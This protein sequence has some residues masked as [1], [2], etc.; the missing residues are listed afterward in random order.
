MP[1]VVS[2]NCAGLQIKSS[3]I[4]IA[5]KIN[6]KTCRAW[7]LCGPHCNSRTQY[8]QNHS[9]CGRLLASSNWC[10]AS[11]TRVTGPRSPRLQG[12]Y[13]RKN[14]QKWAAELRFQAVRE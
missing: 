13:D 11:F 2:A 8:L 10:G 1:P 6:A 5:S 3:K 4:K 12:R 9:N 7:P 14:S